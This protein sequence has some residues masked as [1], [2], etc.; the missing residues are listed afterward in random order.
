MND[1]NRQNA[2]DALDELE[3]KLTELERQ[4]A[5]LN[6]VGELSIDEIIAKI[7]AGDAANS[8]ETEHLKV[9]LKLYCDSLKE[10]LGDRIAVLE[11]TISALQSALQERLQTLV[12]S[13]YARFNIGS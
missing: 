10:A 6:D 8:E 5:D 7:Q 2:D 1:W 9:V 4:L 11:A 3:A 13:R 12:I